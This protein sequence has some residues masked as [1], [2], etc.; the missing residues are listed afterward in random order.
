MKTMTMEERED[1]KS[2]V[3]CMTTEDKLELGKTMMFWMFG[4]L[5]ESNTDEAQA[6]FNKLNEEVND[7]DTNASRSDGA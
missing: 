6:F 4:Y 7:E 1:V 3:R 2:R 5:H